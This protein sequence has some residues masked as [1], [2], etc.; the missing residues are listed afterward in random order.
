LAPLLGLPPAVLHAS[1][2]V[3]LAQYGVGGARELSG[4]LTC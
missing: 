2:D 4:W 1:L 3:Q